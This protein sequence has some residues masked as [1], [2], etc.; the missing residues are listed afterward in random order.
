MEIPVVSAE[1]FVELEFEEKYIYYAQK[2]GHAGTELET[3]QP[4]T[5]LD[6]FRDVNPIVTVQVPHPIIGNQTHHHVS[7]PK[8]T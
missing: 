1:T 2:F 5:E 7:Q 3:R 8:L 6:F 4:Y